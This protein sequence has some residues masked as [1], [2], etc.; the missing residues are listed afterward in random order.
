M[1][2]GG[3]KALPLQQGG[4]PSGIGVFRAPSLALGIAGI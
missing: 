3:S 2:G 1:V 4:I